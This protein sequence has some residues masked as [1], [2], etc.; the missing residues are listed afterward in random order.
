MPPSASELE[1]A[2]CLESA[3]FSGVRFVE[4]AAD[5]RTADIVAQRAGARWA[6]EVRAASRLLRGDASFAP[7]GDK[8]LPYPTL[9]FYFAL[10]WR[11][12][13]EQLEA[14]RRVEACPRGMLLILTEGE[15]DTA[16]TRAL[17][18]AWAAAGSPRD[19]IFGVACRGRLLAYP[20]ID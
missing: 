6:I 11:E 18:R 1:A 7:D 2:R 20:G 9:E 5:R 17:E 19:T 16:W 13:R 8:P 14:T 4:T 3:G 15:P 12:K 10:A